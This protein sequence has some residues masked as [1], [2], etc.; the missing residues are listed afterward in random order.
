MIAIRSI[1]LPPYVSLDYPRNIS[2]Q[3]GL[4]CI[5]YSLGKISVTDKGEGTGTGNDRVPCS[6]ISVK[7]DRGGMILSLSYE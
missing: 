1:L 3:N 4:V 6:L 7:A 5:H 2:L